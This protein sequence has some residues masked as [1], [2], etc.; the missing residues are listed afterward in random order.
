MKE[1]ILW[2]LNFIRLKIMKEIACNLNWIEI[3][4]NWIEFKFTNWIKNKWDANWL[5]K[6]SKFV[7]DC[8][9]GKKGFENTHIQKHMFSGF[10]VPWHLE[11]QLRKLTHHL[12]EMI[13]VFSLAGEEKPNCLKT[14]LQRCHA[15]WSISEHLPSA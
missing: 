9:V 3:Q 13:S 1:F 14:C 8:G 7:R 2:K 12:F 10:R 5:L 11:D 6:K 4:F 15:F